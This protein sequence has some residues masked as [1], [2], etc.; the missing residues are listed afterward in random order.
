MIGLLI[1][2]ATMEDARRLFEWRNDEQTRKQS[3]NPAPVSWDGHVQWLEKSLKNPKRI[4]C[5]AEVDGNAIG[6]MRADERDDGYTEISYTIAPYVRGKGFSK[7]M[8]LKFVKEYLAGRAIAAHIKKGHA[9][10]E[11]VTKA[12]G[13]SPHHETPSADPE[14]PRPM[15]EWR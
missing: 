15:V 3:R 10:S 7:L 1:K 11:S 6:T 9:P 4:L 14:D 2:R 13:L 12:L 8:V 5:I